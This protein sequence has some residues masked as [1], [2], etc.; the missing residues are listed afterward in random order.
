MNTI[1]KLLFGSQ[2]AI[3]LRLLKS[4]LLAAESIQKGVQP[5][6]A[7]FAREVFRHLPEGFK[8]PKGPATEQEF[9][10]AVFNVFA[11]F[12]KSKKAF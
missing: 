11:L 6:V 1:V 5:N 4:G 3:A 7:P 10:D 8:H 9:V 2:V 12:V